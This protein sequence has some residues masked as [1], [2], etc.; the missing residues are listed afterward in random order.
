MGAVPKLLPSTTLTVI[1]L[2]AAS[3][4]DQPVASPGHPDLG[5]PFTQ[6]A[7]LLTLTCGYKLNSDISQCFPANTLHGQ[8]RN[9]RRKSKPEQLSCLQDRKLKHVPGS[10][11]ATHKSNVGP[12][13]TQ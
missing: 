9:M 8:V 4:A 1:Q 3:K 11:L 7:E 5:E 2:S 6:T 12:A 10:D 13:R